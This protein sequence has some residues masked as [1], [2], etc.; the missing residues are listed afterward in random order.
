MLEEKE[1]STEEKI[2]TEIVALKD[3]LQQQGEIAA[4]MQFKIDELQ[5]KVKMISIAQGSRRNTIATLEGLMAPEV[6]KNDKQ[7]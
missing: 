7:D 4:Q 1:R 6:P 2:K 3:E 5:Q